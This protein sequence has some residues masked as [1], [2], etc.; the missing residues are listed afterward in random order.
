M[1]RRGLGDYPD[2]IEGYLGCPFGDRGSSL[3]LRGNCEQ[4]PALAVAIIR[5]LR[6][7]GEADNER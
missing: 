7:T 5:D 6:I 2:K 3:R 4:S 1:K